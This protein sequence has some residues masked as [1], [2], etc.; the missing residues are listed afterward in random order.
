MNPGAQK[1]RT[2]RPTDQLAALEHFYVKGLG[3]HVLGRFE[4]HNGYDGLILDFGLAGVEIEFTSHVNGSPC[5]APSADNLLVFY[6]ENAAAVE[7]VRQRMASIGE[8][9]VAPENPYWERIS[10]TFADPDGWR[11]TL[12]DRQAMAAK[13]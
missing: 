8:A 10:L 6:L 3:L 4:G 12:V 11:V 13:N 1:F 9:P 7:E 5:P 2:A